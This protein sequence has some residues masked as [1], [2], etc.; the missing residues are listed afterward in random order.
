MDRYNVC[1]FPL[2]I[3]ETPLKATAFVWEKNKNTIE[4]KKTI[5]KNHVFL[6][7]SGSGTFVF[8]NKEFPLQLGDLFFGFK[9]ETY[10]CINFNNLEYAYLKFEG[11]RSND[12]FERFSI[13]KNNRVFSKLDFLIPFWKESL[14]NANENN[15]DLVA[16]SILLH[17]FS[18]LKA[19]KKDE[20]PLIKEILTIT[21]E[22]LSN[23]SF[24]LKVL[25]KELNYNEK[26]LS[27]LFK[28]HAKVGFIEYLRSL[29]I[30]N[31]VSLFDMGLNSVKNV[32]LLSGFSDPLYFSAVF[33]KEMGVSP[34][35]YIN[36][37]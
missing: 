22:N 21:T 15:M 36:K 12:L 33:K 30:K 17:T 9:G 35:Q 1:K 27:H 26:Y 6:I 3:A 14:F 13:T 28:K 11:T 16:E 2:N 20:Q 32:A 4:L 25:A 7:T 19:E 34:K 29:R 18:K 23:P 37:E 31:A 10:N 5:N 24:N 8:N